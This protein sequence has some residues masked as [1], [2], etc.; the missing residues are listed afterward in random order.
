MCQFLLVEAASIMIPRRRFFVGPSGPMAWLPGAALCAALFFVA[1]AASAQSAVSYAPGF[2]LD[3]GDS[4]AAGSDHLTL[5]PDCDLVL[6]NLHDKVLWSSNSGAKTCSSPLL[7]Y[8]GAGGLTITGTVAGVAGTTVWTTG[9]SGTTEL[10]VTELAPWIELRNADA[11]IAWS[12]V[13]RLADVAPAMVATIGFN[14]PSYAYG[15]L[16]TSPVTASPGDDTDQFM[17]PNGQAV[18]V[19][20]KSP[21]TTH[22]Y[23]APKIAAGEDPAAYF[24]AVLAAAGNGAVIVIPKGTYNFAPIDCTNGADPAYRAAGILIPRSQDVVIDGQGSTLNFN[25][26]CVGLDIYQ[27]ARVEFEN[28]T[29]NFP[30]WR[31]AT[32]GTV[33]AVKPGSG[34]GSFSLQLPAGKRVASVGVVTA[35]DPAANG[36]SLT[37][38]TD[39]IYF[40]K[41]YTPNSAG[42]VAD[43]PGG[44]A[45]TVGQ[46]LLARNLTGTANAITVW[47]SQDVTLNHVTIYNSPDLGIL[48]SFGRGLH[49]NHVTVTRTGT[50]PI[51]TTADAV[52]FGSFGGDVIIENSKFAYQGDDGLNLH[53]DMLPLAVTPSCGAGSSCPVTLPASFGASNGDTIALF[54]AATTF[55]TTQP[56][57]CGPDACTVNAAAIAGGGFVADLNL[58]NARYII[59]GNVFADNR[60]RGALLQAPYGLVQNNDFVD[61]SLFAMYFVVSSY[62]QEGPGAQ[63][64]VVLNNTVS[65]PG[66]GGGDGAVTVAAENSAGIVYSAGAGAGAPP[67]LPGTNQNLIFAHNTLKDLPGAAFYISSANNVILDQNTLSQTNLVKAKDLFGNAAIN[68][69]YAT[70][71][72]DASNVLMQNNTLSGT[73]TAG[74]VTYDPGSTMNLAAR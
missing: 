61:Q 65:S 57:A 26:D 27:A 52:H 64:V 29:I 36:W 2:T 46:S 47:D 69:N 13:N 22:T 58:S 15:A 21:V 55:V 49:L 4:I 62:W 25:S 9:V 70:V 38:P 3:A 30:S 16:A 7:T 39:E 59:R 51:S 19:T 8:Q 44:Q 37:K 35:W 23:D 42:L 41:S 60:A 40:A 12:T 24:Q 18:T 45:F 54:N 73:A 32:V 71:I 56:A 20:V 74:L 67:P 43:L 1:G 28:L 5:Q 68:L 14:D 63:N 50:N 72:D 11:S 31:S 17:A 6:T 10:L 53:T 34:G 66:D 48:I 33:A